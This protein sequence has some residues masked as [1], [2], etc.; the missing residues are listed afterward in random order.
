MQSLNRAG[1][2]HLAGGRNQRNC[3]TIVNRVKCFASRGFARLKKHMEL[4]L[5]NRVTLLAFYA[6]FAAS[7]CFANVS[8]QVDTN[9][10]VVF[11]LNL[12]SR[13]GILLSNPVSHA[14]IVLTNGVVTADLVA[15]NITLRGTNLFTL[16]TNLQA[17]I[18]QVQT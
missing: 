3:N 11:P 1:P 12:Q 9:G 13:G 16:V 14:T 8:P 18:A 17:Q 15:A 10:W 4:K 6:A 2:H 5:K 7:T